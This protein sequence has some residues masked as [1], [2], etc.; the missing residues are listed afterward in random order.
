MVYDAFKTHET[1]NGKVLL[2]TNNTDL[3]IVPA[4]S[5]STCQ[6]L[7]ACVNKPF[8]VFYVIQQQCERQIEEEEELLED[9]DPFSFV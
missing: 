4:G 1:D 7:D 5:T 8:R 9:E 3:V 6:P 2:A